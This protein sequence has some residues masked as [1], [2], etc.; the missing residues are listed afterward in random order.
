[1]RAFPGCTLISL[2]FS[3]ALLAACQAG[4]LPG[5]DT[6]SPKIDPQVAAAAQALT[7]DNTTLTHTDAQ[8]R[9]QVYVYVSDSTPDTLAAL[10]RAGL[11]NPQA[12]PA[13]LVVE[14][15]IAPRDLAGLAALPSVV[16][17]TLPRYASPR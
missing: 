6:S 12:A 2:C 16:K 11:V 15:W 7:Q 13:M 3:L 5:T 4:A 1:M 10:G 17:I 14:G 9:L 8:G